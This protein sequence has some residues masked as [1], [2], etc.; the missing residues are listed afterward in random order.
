MRGI[1]GLGPNRVNKYTFGKATQGI[2]N[3]LKSISQNKEISVVIGRDCRNN[4]EK[5]QEVVCNVFSG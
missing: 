3:F 1:M 2:C 5:L 4:G